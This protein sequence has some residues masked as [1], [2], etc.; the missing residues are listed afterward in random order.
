MSEANNDADCSRP[1]G[2][3]LQKQYTMTVCIPQ[4]RNAQLEHP[5]MV[6]TQYI[7]S[8]QRETYS[9]SR[10]TEKPR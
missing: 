8:L 9:L 2:V 7:A 3:N 10:Q 1:K 6:E 4:C 5:R